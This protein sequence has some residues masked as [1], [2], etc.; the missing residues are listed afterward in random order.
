[1]TTESR[2]GADV[3]PG[4][5]PSAVAA[6]L[7]A[8]LFGYHTAACNAPLSALARDL[9]FADDDYVK[10]AVVSALVI[11]G[12]IGGLT[13]GGLSDKY[14]RKWALT[15]TSAPLALGTM[16]SGMAPNAVTMI[17]GRF[18]CGLGVGASSQIVPLYLS[19]IA[20]P[21]L[22]GTL[23]G[24]RRLAYVFGCLAAFQLAAP[25]KETGGEGWWRPIFYDAAIPALMLAVGAAFVAQETPVWLLTQSDE[26]AAEKSR[27]S[28]AILQ[29]I[30]GRAAEQK[31]STWSE[32]ISDDKNRLPL[33]L[34]LSL[35]ALAAFSGSNTVIFYASTVFTSVGI[36]NP[37]ILTWAVGVPNVVGGFVALALSDKMGRR[38]LLLTSFGGMS[39]CLGILSL[40]AAGPAQPEAA[41]ALVT[42]PLYVLF[43][44]L[45]AGPI[46]W[47]LY[48]EVF[49][50]RIRA[51]AVSACTA[52]NYV[53]NSIVGATFLPMVGAYGLSGS[54]GFY[55]LLCASGYVFVDRFIPETKGLRL[56]DVESTLKRH[57]RKRSTSR[58]KS[59]DE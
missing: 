24:F 19:E 26:K 53:S 1:M 54:Y 51:R 55:T 40:A 12:A 57:A 42:I 10:G 59:I 27:R 35:C 4:L 52:L 6:S 17:A 16:L 23:N 7:G 28:L 32:L 21:A 37:E 39:A 44:S 22:R 3:G 20:P 47:L 49:P 45:G 8:F 15:A 25:L 41:V 48:N 31:L 38:P 5:A 30:R 56:E 34:G 2:R 43:F 50:T 11:G 13:V 58:S 14:G 29:N 9:G 36:N 33:S 46:P 18:I